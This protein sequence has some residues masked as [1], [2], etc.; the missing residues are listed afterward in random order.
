MSD[1]GRRRGVGHGRVSPADHSTKRRRHFAD[2][3]IRLPQENDM[4]GVERL[5]PETAAV[6]VSRHPPGGF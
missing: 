6:V 3:E 5:R 4:A 2:R 1:E